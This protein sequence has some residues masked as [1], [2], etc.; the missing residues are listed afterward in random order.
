LDT[1]ENFTWVLTPQ[2]YIARAEKIAAACNDFPALTS[3]L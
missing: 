2:E 1:T 3:R